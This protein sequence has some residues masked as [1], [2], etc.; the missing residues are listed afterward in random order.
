MIASGIDW[1]SILIGLSLFFPFAAICFGLLYV[2]ASK[3]SDDI[4]IGRPD[5]YMIMWYICLWGL[6]WTCAIFAL[7]I[8][9]GRL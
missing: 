9:M 1:S 5:L 8:E 6:S 3:D 4:P 7:V 2:F